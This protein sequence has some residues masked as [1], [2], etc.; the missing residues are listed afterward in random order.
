VSKK[1][2]QKKYPVVPPTV[3]EKNA[4]LKALRVGHSLRSASAMANCCDSTTRKW[5]LNDPDFK[6]EVLVAMERGKASLVAKII[7]AARGSWQAAAWLLERMHWDEFGKQDR[8]TEKDMQQFSGRLAA[9]LIARL[10]AK[11][12]AI[13]REVLQGEALQ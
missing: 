8:F 9:A 2:P 3:Q 1:K 12:H 11:T 13:I 5:R 7:K 6:K 4:F 10:P